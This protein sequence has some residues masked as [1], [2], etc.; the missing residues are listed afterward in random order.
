MMPVIKHLFFYS[1]F[2][3][4]N[5]CGSDCVE[6]FPVLQE[7]EQLNSIDEQEVYPL[8]DFETIFIVPEV[9]D[10][11]ELETEL[12]TSDVQAS[13][14]SQALEGFSHLDE[15]VAVVHV[16]VPG[17]QDTQAFLALED[18]DEDDIV[19]VPH[20][21]INSVKKAN[22]KKK[23]LEKKERKSFLKK[24]KRNHA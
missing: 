15:Q 23:K 5:L 7:I 2:L 22:K 19:P 17:L 21:L 16:D 4:G 18:E 24:L 10:D 1:L 9:Q 11:R 20:E 8:E 13:E 3:A 12:M 6:A 14:E